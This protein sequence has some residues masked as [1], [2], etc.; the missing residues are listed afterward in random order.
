MLNISS[1]CFRRQIKG[2]MTKRRRETIGGKEEGRGMCNKLV[3]YYGNSNLSG[4][5]GA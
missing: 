3:L 2:G 1:G 4:A 5:P